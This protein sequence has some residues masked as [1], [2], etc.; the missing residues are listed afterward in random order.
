MVFRL[1]PIPSV[2]GCNDGP[3]E[4]CLAPDVD[5]T[6]TVYGGLFWIYRPDSIFQSWTWKY[7][8]HLDIISRATCMLDLVPCQLFPYGLKR[9]KA[10]D[11]LRSSKGGCMDVVKGL[12]RFTPTAMLSAIRTSVHRMHMSGCFLTAFGF[13]MVR[14][15]M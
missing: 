6:S 8:S 13:G 11:K 15:I 3:L 9:I 7:Y 10:R 14:R 2:M 5:A 12:G 1:S 4:L